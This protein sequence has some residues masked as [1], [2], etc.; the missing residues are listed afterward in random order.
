MFLFLFPFE[1]EGDKQLE[2]ENKDTPP[3]SKELKELLLPE[4]D[5]QKPDKETNVYMTNQMIIFLCAKTMD[6]PLTDTQ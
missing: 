3:P 4:T 1:E 2:C 6:R 5:R